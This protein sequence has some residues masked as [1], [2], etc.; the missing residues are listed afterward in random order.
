MTNK[1]YYTITV[2]RDAEDG[3]FISVDEA[4]RRK[5]TAIVQRIKIKK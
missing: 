3:T 4:R 5:N 2:G 1:K